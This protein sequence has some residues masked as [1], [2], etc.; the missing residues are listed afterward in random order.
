MKI[1]AILLSGIPIAAATTAM[2]QSNQVA[3]PAASK[4]WS[5]CIA[6]QSNIGASG[7][8]NAGVVV[9][10]SFAQCV[11]AEQMLVRAL[12]AQRMASSDGQQ[13]EQTI[14]TAVVSGL[15]GLKKQHRAAFVR[16]VESFRRQ[17]ASPK[18]VSPYGDPELDT[19]MARSA[20]K[21]LSAQ[22]EK[23]KI[24]KQSC[25]DR[26]SYLALLSIASDRDR[27]VL[28]ETCAS[29]RREE[30]KRRKR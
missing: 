28:I 6:R 29:H 5:D 8:E 16:G 22:S 9:D 21:V 11:A 27:P 26:D 15:D 7:S 14:S 24:Y 2:A 13:S 20:Q 23:I 10:R 25:G 4:T 3:V 30:T 12:V 19:L 18:T 1:A 17:T